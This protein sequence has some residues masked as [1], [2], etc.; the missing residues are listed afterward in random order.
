MAPG[1]TTP[2]GGNIGIVGGDRAANTGGAA[3][4]VGGMAIMITSSKSSSVSLGATK[5]YTKFWILM[6]NG[7]MK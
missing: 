1:C 2:W 5:T 7:K 3:A 6:G 4:I